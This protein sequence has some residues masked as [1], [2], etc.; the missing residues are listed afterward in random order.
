MYRTFI[1]PLSI[2]YPLSAWKSALYMFKGF[3]PT[4]ATNTVPTRKPNTTTR[5]ETAPSDWMSF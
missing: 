3:F 1:R 4:R 5:T 2:L